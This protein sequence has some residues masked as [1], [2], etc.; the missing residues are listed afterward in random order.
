ML[1]LFTRT[2]LIYL[3]ISWAVRFMGK[4]QLGEL[5]PTELITTVMISNL[6]SICIEEPTLP[7]FY[8]LI[9]VLL[10]TALELL[11][12]A[13]AFRI[14]AYGRFLSGK[15]IPVIHDGKI[16]QD[17]LREMR[18]SISDLL[19]AL[20]GQ[21]VFS[22]SEAALAIVE[23]DGSLSV[24]PHQET[25]FYLPLLVDGC[26]IEDNLQYLGLSHTWLLQA[27]AARG[28][29]QDSEIL[30]VLG[31]GTDLQVIPIKNSKGEGR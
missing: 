24:L 7:V 3:V 9:P 6:A 14:P 12:S 23:T 31:N 11:N 5:S 30:L 2:L 13:L 1:F 26:M 27:L 29:A 20:R 18:L 21:G 10:I 15:P 4:R 16:D 19:K 25:P 17:N 22:P 8:S 28:Y